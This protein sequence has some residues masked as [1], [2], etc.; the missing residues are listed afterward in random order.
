MLLYS[1]MM[2]RYLLE[3]FTFPS[4]TSLLEMLCLWQRWAHGASTTLLFA[5]E[6]AGEPADRKHPFSKHTRKSIY[7]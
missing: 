1:D 2:R 5:G 4:F 6:E 3:L 7:M